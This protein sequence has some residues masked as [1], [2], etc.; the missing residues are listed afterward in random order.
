MIQDIKKGGEINWSTE[1]EKKKMNHIHILRHFCDM[2][3]HLQ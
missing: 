3:A 1:L 2:S